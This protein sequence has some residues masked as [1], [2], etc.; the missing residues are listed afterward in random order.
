M[1]AKRSADEQQKARALSRWENEGGARGPAKKPKR[2]RDLNQWAKHIV[3]LATGRA[4]EPEPYEG[5]DTAA[6]SLGHRGGLKVGKARP[7]S[8]TP[9]QWAEI[10]RGC[11]GAVVEAV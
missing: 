10:A 1:M 3:D 4:Q 7:E 9:D 6:V 2:P 8:M 5:K 11:S